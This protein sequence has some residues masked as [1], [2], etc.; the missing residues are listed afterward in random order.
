MKTTHL[1]GGPRDQFYGGEREREDEI[2]EEE[3]LMEGRVLKKEKVAYEG[4]ALVGVGGEPSLV[5][6]ARFCDR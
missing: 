2:D 5:E 1:I 4:L 3:A 6:T